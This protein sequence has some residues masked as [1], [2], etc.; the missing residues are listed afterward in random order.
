[1]QEI[2][3]EFNGYPAVVRMPDE[4]NGEWIWK[5]EFF[6]AFDRAEQILNE[7]GYTR[8]YYRISDMYGSDRA[9]RLMHAFHLH[10]IQKFLLQKKSILFGF[11]R[12]GL[13]AFNY[14]LYYPEYVCKVYLD[15]PVLDLKTWPPENS[16]EQAQMLCEYCLNAQTLQTFRGNPVDNLEEFFRAAIP[17]LLVAGGKDE[18]VPFE[19]NSLQVIRYC[20]KKGIA[21]QYYVKEN[22]GHHPHSLTPPDAIVKFVCAK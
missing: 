7:K 6:E 12:G 8:V 18:V 17:L 1:M 15:A 4:P 10:L 20:E 5:T 3:F 9:V 11:S 14:A 2:K 21:L 16:P 19:K 22:C 13:Y